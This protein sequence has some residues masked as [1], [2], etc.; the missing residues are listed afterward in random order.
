MVR[1]TAK[2]KK[3]K[4]VSKAKEL[5][6][7]N[8]ALESEI[9][10]RK[11]ME[12]WLLAAREA[13]LEGAK[14]KSRFVANISH[15]IRTPVHVI[16]GMLYA[17]KETRLSEQQQKYLNTM[18]KAADSLIVLLNDILDFSKVEAGKLN[19]HA[20]EFDIRELLE[21]ST[22]AASR[23]AI[24][25]GIGWTL[26][27]DPEI[28]RKYRAD[29]V[30]IRQILGN[31]LSNAFKFTSTGE[32]SLR[33]YEESRSGSKSHVRFEVRDSGAGIPESIG[34]RIFE[35]FLQVD[36]SASRKHGG[37]GLGLSICKKL[38]ELLEGS[39]GYESKEGKGSLF[40]FVVPM[41]RVTE[42]TVSRSSPELPL[43]N[44]SRRQGRILV[45]EDNPVN[46]EVTAI[47]LASFGHDV[48]IAGD[49]REGIE[50]ARVFE[51]DL[52]IMDCQMP[53]LDGFQT[54]AT[55]RELESAKGRRTP[56]IAMTADAMK[57][58]AERCLAAG[59]DEYLSKPVEV[60]RLRE[61]IDF[62]LEFQAADGK[63]D[64]EPKVFRINESAIEKLRTFKAPGK[65]NLFVRLVEI[66]LQ[67]TPGRIER[68]R[69]AVGQQDLKTIE[70]EA[71]YLKSSSMTL[72]AEHLSR[73]CAGLEEQGRV[74]D[75]SK[76]PVLFKEIEEEFGFAAR[77]LRVQA[78]IPA[79][80]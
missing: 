41:H 13:A 54:T 70:A 52:I 19:V 14:I 80:V 36:N 45:V 33:V 73:L 62:W 10:E 61:K 37:A 4:P 67:D 17:L 21:Q 27:V 48:D 31:I 30:R 6:R 15:E 34:N 9:R 39:I 26:R 57:D 79:S 43:K 20:K 22:A 60:E 5:N 58:A 59:M 71:H 75:G 29:P 40:W 2:G 35:E 76:A 12:K 65:A 38:V 74:F 47:L 25:R 1:T 8:L 23:E 44:P 64:T 77:E 24:S 11:E 53:E 28:A 55:I 68:L 78:G 63:R 49:G 3:K 7:L 51:Y 18:Q 32:I 66:Y 56:I 42:A 50:K 69:K 16:T 46:Q 72:G